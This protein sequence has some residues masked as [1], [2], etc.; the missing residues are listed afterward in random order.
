MNN[1]IDV[2]N[3]SIQN[4]LINILGLI[5]AIFG[6]VIPLHKDRKQREKLQH[7]FETTLVIEIWENMNF[8]TS[9]EKSY[10]NNL[11]IQDPYIH[12]PKFSPRIAVLEKLIDIQMLSNWNISDLDKQLILGIYQD[13]IEVKNLFNKWKINLS[14]YDNLTT[15]ANINRYKEDSVPLLEYIDVVM[16]NSVQLFCSLLR[17]KEFI[18]SISD[19][20]I[21]DMFL[22]VF[23]RI[24]S[25]QKEGTVF[26]STYKSSYTREGIYKPQ[27]QYDVIICWED[28]L[29][30]CD[31]EIIEL[32]NIIPL[33][34]SWKD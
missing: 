7:F 13:T 18:K 15:E 10:N 4:N 12:D 28:D 17:N 11:N 20:R 21:R 2:I 27:Y 23:D 24:F 1:L 25:A 3:C 33:H 8:I 29:K 5:I 32:K 16:R 9:I 30:D 26:Y 6:L 14:Q 31:K 19:K 34:N 22:S